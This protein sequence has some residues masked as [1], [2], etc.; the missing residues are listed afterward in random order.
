MTTDQPPVA[1]SCARCLAWGV[2]APRRV[3]GSCITWGARTSAPC[4]G[5]RRD[6][7]LRYGFCRLCRHQATIHIGQQ[8]IRGPIPA[9]VQLAGWQLFFAGMTTTRAAI[10]SSAA[11]T[12]PAQ[13][14]HT[15]SPGQ[16]ALL[17]CPRDFTRFWAHRLSNPANPALIA[18][19]RT[20]Q[21]RGETY[22]WSHWLAAEVDRGLVILL[23]QLIPGDRIRYSEIVPLDYRSVDVSR[24]AEVLAELDLLHDDRP[25]PLDAW[26][27]GKLSTLAPGIAEAVRTWATALRT[28]QLRTKVHTDGTVRNYLRDVYPHLVAW[29]ADRNHLREITGDD[30]RGR[31]PQLAGL[32]RKRTLVALRSLFGFAHRNRI[33]FTNPTAGIK[34]GIDGARLPRRIPDHQLQRIARASMTPMRR[35]LVALTAIHAARPMHLQNILLDDVDL[36][37]RRLTIGGH[38]RHLDDLTHQLLVDY[39]RHRQSRWPRT[40]NHHLLLTERR[41]HDLAPPST[42]WLNA[43]FRAIGATPTQLRMDRQLEEALTHGPD[44]LHLAA[45]F[46]IAENTAVRYARAARQLLETSLEVGS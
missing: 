9:G 21:R 25:D 34:P 28:G 30:I 33:T 37:N 13:T 43:E 12:Q 11:G 23:S 39:L 31:L 10:T 32:E 5:C 7:P 1:A 14:G 19:R 40:S 6:V 46:G 3:C 29:S 16:L 42:Y 22:G 20:A 44:P 24:T 27:N 36:P 45:V 4:L 18:A 38:T 35:L 17:N 15:E 2:H 26:I 8:R 41:G